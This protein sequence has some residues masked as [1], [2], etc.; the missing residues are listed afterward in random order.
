MA[1][2]VTSRSPGIR[3]RLGTIGSLGVASLIFAPATVFGHMLGS[4]Y[5]TLSFAA[6][7]IGGALVAANL[8]AG[9]L[10][11]D[12]RIH[13]LGLWL[14]P[15]LIVAILS[16]VRSPFGILNGK[17][18]A[19]FIGLATTLLLMIGMATSC[20]GRP[21]I[22]FALLNMVMKVLS[23]IGGIAIFQFIINNLLQSY[24][25]DFAWLNIFA[26]DLV[27]SAGSK[28]GG[29]WRA[30]SLASEPSILGTFLTVGV[31]P[32][33]LRLGLAGSA[34]R[35]AIRPFMSVW[36]AFAI[37]GG[38]VATLSSLGYLA[39]LLSLAATW[40][41][42]PRVRFARVLTY[43]GIALALLSAGATTLIASQSELASKLLTLGLITQAARGERIKGVGTDDVTALAIATNFTV[44]QKNLAANPALGVGIGSHPIAFA[45]SDLA[46]FAALPKAILYLNSQDAAS[47]A[48]RLASETGLLGLGVFFI[49]LLG[50]MSTLRQ[51]IL[52][53]TARVPQDPR[54]RCVA[55]MMVGLSA[56]MVGSAVASLV[57]IGFYF[58]GPFWMSMVLVAALPALYPDVPRRVNPYGN[59]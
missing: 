58:G 4:S 48:I 39:A 40:L 34:T 54:F 1:I 27:I 5:V 8:I 50:S 38:I 20:R 9:R 44:M 12:R 33:M 43:L 7:A 14:I 42:S 28:L 51:A 25:I 59:L 22:Y 35:I 49:F 52:T 10:L 46:I 15:F 55:A 3:G 56:S 24:I 36:S 17:A 16:W 6:T 32:A 47:L 18:F 31:G 41:F 37:V 53:V 26:G 57:R 13:Q 2:A 11:I 29:L 45:A 30:T 19:Q 21:Q 23:A